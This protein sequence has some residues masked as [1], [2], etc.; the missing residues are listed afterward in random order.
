MDAFVTGGSG[1]VGGTLVERLVERGDE[2]CGLARSDRSAEAVARRG[3]TPV[4]GDLSAVDAMAEGMDGCD[5]VFHA[6]AKLDGWGGREAFE[7]VNVRGTENVLEAARRAGVDRLV[8]VSTEAVLADGSPLVGVDE[9]HPIPGDHAGLYGETKAAAERLVVAADGPE[10]STVVVRPR[11]VW[12]VGDTTL[13]PEF[14]EAVQNGD[15]RWIDGGRYP[16]STCHVENVVEGL[17]LAAERGEGGEVYFLTDGDPVEFREFVTELVRTQGVE[18][19]ESSVPRWA[20]RLLATA[21]EW[22]WR[23]PLLSGEPP[24]TRATLAL[25]AQEMTVDDSKARE[26]LGYDPPVSVEEGLDALR[27]W[28]VD[29]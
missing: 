21:A 4:R 15:W 22:A 5:V 6:A 14:V 1:F 19:G 8:H 24:L 29:A 16:T 18:P 17:V 23:L 27:E 20:A 11:L 10:L 3:A 7:R 25:G 26:R 9:T 2:V 13:L 28:D 12:G